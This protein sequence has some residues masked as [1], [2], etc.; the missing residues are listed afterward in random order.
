MRILLNHRSRF[1]RWLYQRQPF[2]KCC[3]QHPKETLRFIQ[4]GNESVIG[5]YRVRLKLLLI[6]IFFYPTK[7]YNKSD[8]K[9]EK[10]N[11]EGR[12]KCNINT[13]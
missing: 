9:L 2:V 8:S 4:K 1:H 6:V 12:R 10:T 3:K 13:N 11:N 7:L 5:T